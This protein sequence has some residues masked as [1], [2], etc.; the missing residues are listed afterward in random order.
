VPHAAGL[1]LPR[2]IYRARRAVRC[3]MHPWSVLWEERARCHVFICFAAG[4]FVLLVLVCLP[5]SA[6]A[7]GGRSFGLR[8]CLVELWLI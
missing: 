7:A 8:V 1:M 6:G 3:T 4:R 5:A 2:P